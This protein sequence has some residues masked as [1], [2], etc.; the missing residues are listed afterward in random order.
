MVMEV[1]HEDI[2]EDKMQCINHPYRNSTPSPGGICVFC[3]QEKL[4]KLVSSSSFSCSSYPTSVFPYSSS[5]SS[6]PSSR[7]AINGGGAV[8]QPPHL[9]SSRKSVRFPFVLTHKKTKKTKKFE[10]GVMTMDGSDSTTGIAF[11]RSKSTAT[12]RKEGNNNVN[13]NI[14]FLDENHSEDSYSPIKRVFWSFLHLSKHSTP[15]KSD[16]HFK[17]VNFHTATPSADVT[18]TVGSS[19]SADDRL[20]AV[21][22]Y[23][24][25]PPFESRVLRTRSVGCGSRRFSG[26]FFE[27]ISTGFGD[28]TLRRVESQSEGS[29]NKSKVQTPQPVQRNIGND[30]NDNNNDE[31]QNC[32][33]ERVK[34]GGIFSGFMMA[35]VESKSWIW[36]F[37]SPIR[38][39]GK[40]LNGKRDANNNNSNNYNNFSNKNEAT[41]LEAIPSLLYVS[42]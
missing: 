32:H 8:L 4:E 25:S 29:S 26:D 15:K 5:S 17:D 31:G 23:H 19:K 33:K 1:V 27:K 28:C 13:N 20:V 24:N 16:G 36:A 2:S 11:N 37:A 18:A 22:E 34:C 30:S 12:S 6:P 21:D 35:S 10:D 41:N 42:G 3:L 39:F 7:S 9:A 40:P 38:A 14:H